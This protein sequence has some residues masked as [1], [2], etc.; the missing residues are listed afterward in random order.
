MDC[1]PTVINGIQILYY[2]LFIVCG[3]VG[4]VKIYQYNASNFDRIKVVQ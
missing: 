1:H 4:V 3:Y 2:P